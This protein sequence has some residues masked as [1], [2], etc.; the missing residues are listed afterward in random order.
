MKIDIPKKY[1]AKLSKAW[2]DWAEM[3]P[4]FGGGPINILQQIRESQRRQSDDTFQRTRPPQGVTVQYLYV[5]LFELFQIE[6]FERL[7]KLLEL[8][9]KPNDESEKSL[10][11][12]FTE[13]AK[14]ITGSSWWNLGTLSRDGG[15]YRTGQRQR[16]L[17][18][19][20]E[21]VVQIDIGAFQLMPSIFVVTFDIRLNEKA[22]TKL[23]QLQ[24]RHYLP[25]ILFAQLIPRD[26]MGYSGNM[27]DTVMS[28]EILAWL[29]ELR[30]KVE[31]CLA[32]Y[33]NGYFMQHSPSKLARLPALEVFVFKGVG[34]MKNGLSAWLQESQMW[35]RS[36]GFDTFPLTY[37]NDEV[38]LIPSKNSLWWDET[39]KP[40]HRLIV[41]WERFTKAKTRDGNELTDSSTIYQTQFLLSGISPFLTILEYLGFVQERIEDL[42]QRVFRRVIS[43]WFSKILLGPQSGL[44]DRILQESFLLDRLMTE[45]KQNESFISSAMDAFTE[46]AAKLKRLTSSESAQKALRDD[47]RDTTKHRLEILRENATLIKNWFA[48][49]SALRTAEATSWLNSILVLLTLILVVLT[50]V[51]VWLTANLSLPH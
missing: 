23:S 2:L 31:I 28:Q 47:L 30:G 50:V 21:E 19:L 24:D 15:W 29:E 5:R 7:R 10:F 42:R 9:P 27:A 12:Q 16:K 14:R 34:E 36:L 17:K 32:P 4:K 6:D 45:F 20:P 48:E 43:G 49:Y 51:L 26:F 33:A 44:S 41:L 3:L 13:K 1:R 39:V 37:T 8:F 35:L 38:V 40:P 25:E 18:H 11:Q 22:K 46:D